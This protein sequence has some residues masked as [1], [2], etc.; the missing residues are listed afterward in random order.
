MS[1]C[2]D[3][4]FVPRLGERV[5]NQDLPPGSPTPGT[6]RGT[7]VPTPEGQGEPDGWYW[8]HWDNGMLCMEYPGDVSPVTG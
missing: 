5:W 7:C 6:M 8:V 4:G 2:V 1:E 3:M